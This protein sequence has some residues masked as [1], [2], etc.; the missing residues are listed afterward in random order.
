MLSFYSYCGNSF[1]VLFCSTADILD[2][3]IPKKLEFIWT[4]GEG[5]YFYRA[6]QVLFLR[7]IDLSLCELF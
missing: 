3:E 5:L 2:L 4:V 6:A 7:G 1:I